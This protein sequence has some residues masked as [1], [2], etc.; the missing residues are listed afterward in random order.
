MLP[1]DDSHTVLN[2]E[3]E[4]LICFALGFRMLRR[5]IPEAGHQQ[6]KCAGNWGSL[7]CRLAAVV[8][9]VVIVVVVAV[10]V[11]VGAVV[12]GDGVVVVAVVA[13]GGAGR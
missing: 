10:V 6:C 13:G 12:V 1:N 8:V 4:S 9:V 3:L 2:L 5:G 7:G 11:V